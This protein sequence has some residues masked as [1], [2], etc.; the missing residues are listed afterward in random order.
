MIAPIG[1]FV[2][3]FLSLYSKKYFFRKKQGGEIGLVSVPRSKIREKSAALKEKHP[4][5]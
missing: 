4:V 1:K 3:D 5:K 2:Y